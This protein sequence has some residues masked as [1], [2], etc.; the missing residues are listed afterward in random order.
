[1]VGC[2][3]DEFIDSVSEEF[4]ENG[5]AVVTLSDGKINASQTRA[6]IGEEK[7]LKFRDYTAL[8][9]FED[10]LS[11]LGDDERLKLVNNYGIKSLHNVAIDADSELEIIGENAYNEADFA[12]KYE[13]YKAKYNGVLISNTIDST[14]LSLY[15]PDGDN[16]KSFIGNAKG[17]YL[18]GNQIM[19][20]NLKNNVPES[21]ARLASINA[22]HT[23]AAG[24]YPV[25]SSVYSPKSGKK[26]YLDTYMTGDR[27]WVKMHCRKKMWYGWKNDPHRFYY[28]DTRLKNI[29][30]LIKGA[31]GQDV[32]VDCPPRYI[33]ENNVKDGFSIIIGKING[34]MVVGHIYAWTDMTSEHG[35][36][37]KQIIEKLGQYMIPKCLDEKAQII[38]VELKAV[39]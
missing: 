6:G 25:N 1:M 30:Y 16:V 35:E 17:K 27:V 11:N 2:S 14:D 3:N 7:V 9:K 10:R 8:N 34:D 24:T 23:L 5:I 33:F 28:F 38:R 26:V 36:D 29:S 18:V 31:Y 39:R 21:V 12:S 22:N 13:Q 19:N 20:I 4:D 32:V 37:G 15:V